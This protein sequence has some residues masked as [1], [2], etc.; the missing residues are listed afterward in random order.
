MAKISTATAIITSKTSNTNQEL[1]SLAFFAF[2]ILSII[3]LYRLRF[4]ERIKKVDEQSFLEF[5]TTV[6]L[7]IK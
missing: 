4:S 7:Y 3:S 6:A 1:L 5:Q 2:E